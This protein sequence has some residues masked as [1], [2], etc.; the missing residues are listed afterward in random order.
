[1]SHSAGWI[2]SEFLISQGVFNDPSATQPEW[3]LYYSFMPDA[4]DGRDDIGTIYDTEGVKDG[5]LMRGPGYENIMHPGIQIGV[6]ARDPRVGYAKMAEVEALM[7]AI[8]RIGITI[9]GTEYTIQNVSQVSPQLHIG[10][11]DGT[12]RRHIIVT[13]FLCTIREEAGLPPDIVVPSVATIFAHAVDVL[14]PLNQ[15][16][17]HFHTNA[18]AGS[19][20]VRATLP[21]ATAGLRGWFIQIDSGQFIIDLPADHHFEGTY[22]T[23][24]DGQALILNS[25]ISKLFIF[26][27]GISKRWILV[28]EGGTFEAEA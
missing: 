7:A 9:E 8:A 24:A 25:P 12:Q 18:G 19:S 16:E 15:L 3:S 20:T 10:Q 6:R 21:I 14:I 27:D 1:M 5:R 28:D 13:N 26:T 2:I 11:E 23:F 22:G 4:A 17:G